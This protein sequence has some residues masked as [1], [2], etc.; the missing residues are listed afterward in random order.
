[1]VFERLIIYKTI[2][3]QKLFWFVV[4]VIFKE[5][6]INKYFKYLQTLIKITYYGKTIRKILL[7]YFLKD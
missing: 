6:L 4:V 1:M 2:T 5:S 7:S 3:N